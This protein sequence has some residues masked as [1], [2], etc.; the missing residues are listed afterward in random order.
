MD[1]GRKDGWVAGRT[2]ILWPQRELKKGGKAESSFFLAIYMHNLEKILVLR[3]PKG[4]DKLCQYIAG[5]GP[6]FICFI[7]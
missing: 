6:M 7:D 1:D 4:A 5:S 2:D 3:M